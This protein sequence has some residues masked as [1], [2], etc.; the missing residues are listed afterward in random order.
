MFQLH[1]SDQQFYWLRCNLYKRLDSNGSC[2]FLFH[3]ITWHK[4]DKLSDAHASL[5]HTP[6]VA[7]C[8]GCIG[9]MS[10]RSLPTGNHQCHNEIITQ[11][12]TLIFSPF[13][14]LDNHMLEFT[15]HLRFLLAKR[16]RFMLR[17]SKFKKNWLLDKL[18]NHSHWIRLSDSKSSLVGN[19][20]SGTW[21]V[22]DPVPINYTYNTEFILSTLPADD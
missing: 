1:L 20:Y 14:N 3:H 9:T 7:L 4:K 17:M 15:W 21:L 13:D 10:S 16:V 2:H 12:R 11:D 8:N 18:D 19:V 5:V 22:S 6:T